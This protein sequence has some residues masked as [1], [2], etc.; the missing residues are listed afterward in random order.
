MFRDELF[1]APGLE[2]GELVGEVG[3][4]GE[5]GCAVGC[6]VD[7]VHE[8]TVARAVFFE[9]GGDDFPGRGDVGRL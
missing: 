7:N 8:R 6:L 4:R 9:Q 5:D 1:A 3:A 2:F